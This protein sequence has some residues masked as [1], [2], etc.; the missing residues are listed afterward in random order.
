MRIAPADA[1]FAAQA[2]R[3][4]FS[5]AITHEAQSP[6]DGP[7][8]GRVV[9]VTPYRKTYDSDF[10][11]LVR[12]TTVL[13][14]RDPD[15][16]GF[17]ALSAAWNGFARIEDIGVDVSARRRGVGRA[18]L[19]ASADW[20]KTQRLA[21]LSAET[22]SNNVD[23]CRLYESFGFELGG[24]DRH[25]YRALDFDTRETALFWYLFLTKQVLAH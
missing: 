12:T 4:D 17:V 24:A 6:F 20:A 14:A 13:V 11:E 25:L 9:S 23:A 15:L 5:F 22:Q 3:C 21:G 16:L 18:L 19:R 1:S 10:D 8:L 2:R 7:K